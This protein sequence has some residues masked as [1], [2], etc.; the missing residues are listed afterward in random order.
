MVEVLTVAAHDHHDGGIAEFSGRGPD[1]MTG[2]VALVWSAKPSLI[3]KAKETIELIA[4]SAQPMRASQ[5]CGSFRGQDVPNA[6]YGYGIV[7][8]FRAITE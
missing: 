8:A 1:P 5:T 3:G 7:N 4:R 2:I 6:V